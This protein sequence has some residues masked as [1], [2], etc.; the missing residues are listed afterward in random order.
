ML[1]FAKEA[2]A[3]CFGGPYFIQFLVYVIF[4]LPFIC[5]SSVICGNMLFVIETMAID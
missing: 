2:P 4:F 3:L 1:N 5:L